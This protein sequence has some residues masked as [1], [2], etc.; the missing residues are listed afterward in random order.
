MRFITKVTAIVITLLLIPTSVIA[1]EEEKPISDRKMRLIKT[2]TGDIAPKSVRASGNGL[3]SAHNMMYRHSVTI[4]DGETMELKVTVPDTVNLSDFGFSKFTSP[5]RGA[6]VEGAFSPDGKHLYV[7]NY[8][9]YGKGFNREG[10][11]TCKPSDGYDRAFLYRIELETFSIDKVYRV[12]TVP[13]VVDVSP[14][15]RFVLVSNWCS[16]DLSIIST[17]E[18]TVV[19]TVPIGRYP[20]GIAIS[21]DSR[22][23]YVAEMG[24]STIHRVDLTD[25][26]VRRIPI[27]SNPRALQLSVDDSLLYATLNVSGQV[28]A[29]DLE[30]ERVIKRAKTG[31][32]ARSLAL[33][34]DGTALF[35]V[36]YGSGTMAKVRTSDFKVTA[37]RKVCNRPIGI[38]FENAFDRTWVACYGGSIKVF[39]N[40]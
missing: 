5:G 36:N 16:Y 30:N 23:G 7:T 35:V 15:G 40:R 2:I 3:V 20:R 26:S 9:M 6:P 14:D 27:G 11:D 37:K 34:D 19:K 24:G 12:G 22:F 31:S 17:D 29:L 8:A 28:V 18:E 13:K 32:A 4:Y 33:S 1:M 25:F 10:T 38:T 21:S 39:E